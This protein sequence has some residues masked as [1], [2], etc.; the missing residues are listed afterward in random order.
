MSHWL[1]LS[2]LKRIVLGQKLAPGVT[3]WDGS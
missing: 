2:L 1:R 3:V